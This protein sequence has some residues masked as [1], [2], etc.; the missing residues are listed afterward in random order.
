MKICV[1]CSSS[2]NLDAKYIEAAEKLGRAIANRGHELVF[3]GYDQGLMGACANAAVAAGAPVHGVTTVGLSATGRKIVEGISNVEEENLTVRL[4]RMIAMSDGF[5]TLPGGLGTFEEFF[6]VMSQIKAHELSST[7]ALLSVD[8]YF[9]PLVKM[10][11]LSCETG[12]NSC[13][14]RDFCGEFNNA[15]DA[16][17]FLES[18]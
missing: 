1:F 9:N 6:T 17:E 16:I 4:R 15:E 5:I 7:C 18:R 11:D 8:G 12:L 13:A 2:K 14:W 3:G 10:L